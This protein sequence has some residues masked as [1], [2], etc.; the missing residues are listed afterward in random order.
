MYIFQTFYPTDPIDS[1]TGFPVGLD[2]RKFFKRY[3]G[4][5]SL[6]PEDVYDVFYNPS[7]RHFYQVTLEGIDYAVS[8]VEELQTR[9]DLLTAKG[10][11]GNPYGLFD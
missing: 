1:K 7:T 3:K 2:P 5:G 9:K 4:L 11:L 6:D 8:L 10:I